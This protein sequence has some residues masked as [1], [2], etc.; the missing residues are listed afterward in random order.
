MEPLQPID[1]WFE[2]NHWEP[3][4]FQRKAW[5]AYLLGESG[6]VHVPTGSGKTYA[7][8]MGPLAELIQRHQAG[9]PVKGL[10]VLYITPL[11][12]LSRDV[13]AAIKRP[14]LEL[15]LPFTVESRTGDSSGSSKTRQRKTLPTLLVT[16][17]ESLAILMSYPDAKKQFQGLKA[18]IADEWHELL[19]TKRGVLLELNLSRL[20]KWQPNLKSWGLSATL[21]NLEEAAQAVVGVNQ[22]Y[23]IIS[24]DIKRPVQ[25]ETLLPETIDSFPWGGHLG[26]TLLEQVLKLLEV[27]GSTLVFTNTRFQAERWFQA[28][29][30]RRPAW[31]KELALHHGSLDKEERHFVEAGVKA[32]ELRA[33]VCTSSLDLGVDFPAVEQI[34]QIGSPH[35]LA[36]LIQRAGRAKHRMGESS[37]IYC[38]PTHGLELLEFTALREAYLSQ[39]LESR[40]RF[41]KPFDVL[42]QHLLSCALSEAFN[43]EA[44]FK[45]VKQACPYKQLTEEEFSWVIALLV[46]GG[47]RLQAYPEYHKLTKTDE[48]YEVS[49]KTTKRLHRMN[50]GTITSDASLKVKYLKGATLGTVEE[51]FVSR[52]SAGDIF[53]F[54]GKTLE[55][56]RSEDKVVYVKRSTKQTTTIPRWG[57]GRLPLSES[58]GEQLRQL[59]AS[60]PD[61]KEA[62]ELKVARPLLEA[63]H[64]LSSLPKEDELLI[65]LCKTREGYHCWIYPF[66]GRLV[67]EGLASLWASKLAEQEKASFSLSVND[68]GLELVT[69]KAYPFDTHLIKILTSP[70]GDRNTLIDAIEASL[71]LND[72]ARRQFRDIARITGL[73]LQNYPGNYKTGNQLQTSAS[74][75][76]D[77]FK[78][79]DPDNLLLYQAKKE[80]LEQLFELE[81]LE[82]TLNRI[83]QSRLVIHT[84]KR[85]TPLGFPLLVERLASKLTTESLAERVAALKE[86]W[87]KVAS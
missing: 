60:K 71:N 72:L 74:L 63:Q 5:E 24:A 1:N 48:G 53:T 14:I 82:R 37:T 51:W 36:R 34:I 11:K 17:P 47:S 4:A 78:R 44:L 35:G 22:P 28:I 83:K 23:R 19:G 43:E 16:T 49:N 39:K 56:I 65:E 58:L 87:L 52:L 29:I 85:P 84:V 67:H 61:R 64:E 46:H 54:A 50:I 57:G 68:Y 15:N 77:V 38:V 76:Y 73:V 41:E 27:E 69:K 40:F 30:D 55:F 21:G 12:A 42:S 6:L 32:G 81:R 7:A 62:P 66:E 13:E 59:I 9:E 86:K 25:I 18:V 31:A 79:Y 75:L 26:I 33:V 20:R 3:W 2:K 8:L 70:P 10:Q 45:E 80:V